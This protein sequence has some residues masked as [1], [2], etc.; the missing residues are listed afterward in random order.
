MVTFS[1]SG[2]VGRSVFPRRAVFSLMT[3]FASA[4][5]AGVER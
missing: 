1:P 4:R 3:T 5:I 2:R